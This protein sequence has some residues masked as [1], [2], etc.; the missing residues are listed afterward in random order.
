MIGRRF[1]R[2]GR[3]LSLAMVLAIG[4]TA[5]PVV[6]SIVPA[7]VALASDSD[8]DD[9]DSDDDQDE[10]REDRNLEGQVIELNPDLNPPE[11][12]VAQLGG[13][14]TARILKTDEIAIWGVKVGDY[15]HL[16]GE[17]DRGVFD[18]NELT[19]TERWGSEPS[20]EV[21]DD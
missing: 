16:Q 15:V 14:V 18:A 20:D 19:V 1:W 3:T 7:P 9:K 11:M 12:V 2:I 21:D 13:N 17:Y 4:F 10:D 5:V 6:T 8:R